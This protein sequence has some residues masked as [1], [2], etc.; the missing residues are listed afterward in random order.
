MAEETTEQL[1]LVVI[2]LEAHVEQL[3]VD[4][5]VARQHLVNAKARVRQR[6]RRAVT[7]DAT[8]GTAIA[9]PASKL[10]RAV[11]EAPPMG[12]LAAEQMETQMLGRDRAMAYARKYHNEGDSEKAKKLVALARAY[13]SG[14]RVYEVPYEYTPP[15]GGPKQYKSAMQALAPQPEPLNVI[16]PE[17][18]IIEVP[19]GYVLRPGQQFVN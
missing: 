10:E 17:E 13:A 14:A 5:A 11:W 2:K 9:A 7:I 6:K 4:I 15:D 18:G 16:D 19:P 8:A 3:K 12:A 1:E